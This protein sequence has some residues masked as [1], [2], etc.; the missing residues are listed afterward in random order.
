MVASSNNLP[1]IDNVLPLNV[2]TTSS[3]LKLFCIPNVASV[4]LALSSTSNLFTSS[5]LNGIPSLAKNLTWSSIVSVGKAPIRA[6]PLSFTL[7]A[8]PF[9]R[10]LYSKYLVSFFTESTTPFLNS[11]ANCLAAVVK[12]ESPT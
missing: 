12:L 4:N 3:F 6:L 8:Y 7:G 5:I 10:P 2:E 1:L 11:S 9:L